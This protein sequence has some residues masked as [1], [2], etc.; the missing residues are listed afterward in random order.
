LID[1]L[2]FTAPIAP[3][4]EGAA[5]HDAIE[6]LVEEQLRELQKEDDSLV[7]FFAGHGHTRIEQESETAIS[8][9]PMLECPRAKNTGA[10]TSDSTKG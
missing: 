10:T 3:L 8:F 5:T 9:Q 1:K 4:I 2:G 6:A 7:L